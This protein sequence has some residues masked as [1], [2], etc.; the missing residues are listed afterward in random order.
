MVMDSWGDI[1]MVVLQVITVAEIGLGMW[2]IKEAVKDRRG[3]FV[4]EL[5]ARLR[6]PFL[7]EALNIVALQGDESKQIKTPVGMMT[8]KVAALK[9]ALT[10][11]DIQREAYLSY[12]QGEMDKLFDIAYEFQGLIDL[13]YISRKD[14][15]AFEPYFACLCAIDDNAAIKYIERTRPFPD[16]ILCFL[17]ATNV[18]HV[19]GSFNSSVK[20]T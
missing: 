2:F 16:R 20:P 14:M 15:Y 12:L 1:V 9:N 13:G 3:Q 10:R 17:R 8:L 5:F 7:R 6:D 11:E 19:V 4:L 18:S